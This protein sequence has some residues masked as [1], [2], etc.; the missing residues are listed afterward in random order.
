MNQKRLPEQ[1][2]YVAETTTSIDPRAVLEEQGIAYRHGEWFCGELRQTSHVLTKVVV[3]ADAKIG[4]VCRMEV[5]TDRSD[6]TR[7]FTII[8][9]ESEDAEGRRIVTNQFFTNSED[10]ARRHRWLMRFNLT[11]QASRR[12]VGDASRLRH[13]PT[14]NPE[15]VAED[16][17]NQI[18]RAL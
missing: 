12:D 10:Y 5:Y 6:Q 17:V 14:S 16:V 11:S 4:E 2:V 18:S 7:C 15:V 8:Y 3:N 13:A 1:I 9:R